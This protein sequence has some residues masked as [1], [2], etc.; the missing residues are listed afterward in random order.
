M[1]QE[2]NEEDE[3]EEAKA[4][5]K[6]CRGAIA[7]VLLLL[8][9]LLPLPLLAAAAVAA[10]AAMRLL[11]WESDLDVKLDMWSVFVFGLVCFLLCSIVR[12][13]E[14]LCLAFGL[15]YGCVVFP[16]R[17]TLVALF[18]VVLRVRPLLLARYIGLFSFVC[19]FCGRQLIAV[20]EC[21]KAGAYLL[22]PPLF[23]LS[24]KSEL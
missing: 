11:M 8:L 19:T 21:F 16:D 9:L 3:Q 7:C 10:A 2:D 13:N 6:R 15:F 23:I 18:F 1:Q 20:A 12:M 24:G 22:F 14:R 17:V 4:R 5:K